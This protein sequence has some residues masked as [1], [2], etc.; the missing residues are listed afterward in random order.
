MLFR[1]SA[2]ANLWSETDFTHDAE[3]HIDISKRIFSNLMALG[4]RT[5][6]MDSTDPREAE[7]SLYRIR[8]GSLFIAGMDTY[9]IPWSMYY[10]N[11]HN[12][13]YI[14]AQTTRSGAL[15]CADP[16]YGQQGSI[17]AEVIASVAFEVI[18]VW[19]VSAEAKVFDLAD[20]AQAVLR[21]H[22]KTAERIL[23]ELEVC[24]GDTGHFETLI[25]QISAM[26]VNRYL[27]GRYADQFAF[28]FCGGDRLF[29]EGFFA[30]WEA[31]KQG[32]YMAK[33]KK[34][35]TGLLCD[36]TV[37]FRQIWQREQAMAQGILRELP[38]KAVGRC[39]TPCKFLKKF[40]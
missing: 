9:E 8:E 35:N 20:E 5:E 22:K 19:R 40:D 37:L 23:C 3:H 14:I 13:H 29:D 33:G 18:R 12:P 2:F 15:F 32:L 25:P 27:F 38:A 10:Q 24:K 28:D 16:T 1:S 11:C 39:P 17:S 31:L 6:R 30:K 34:D 7:R 36:I 4:L 26:L 21:T